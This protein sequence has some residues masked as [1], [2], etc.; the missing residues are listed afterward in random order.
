MNLRVTNT[1][2]HRAK[3]LELIEAAQAAS[4]GLEELMANRPPF[5]SSQNA[6]VAAFHRQIGQS[7]KLA[8]VHATLAL[9]ETIEHHMA[10]PRIV[11][12]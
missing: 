12:L 8:H 11:G 9:V 10:K 5:T 6:D 3:A 4:Q 2:T 1:P 7:I